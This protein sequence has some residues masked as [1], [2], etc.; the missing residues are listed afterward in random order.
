M[1]ALIGCIM[2][3]AVLEG[4]L[5]AQSATESIGQKSSTGSSTDTIVSVAEFPLVV[6]VVGSQYNNPF[7]N[8]MDVLARAEDM[9]MSPP[10]L[11]TLNATVNGESHWSLICRRENVK[12][13]SNPCSTLNPGKYPARWIHGGELLQLVVKND[14]GKFEW[15]FFD[16]TPKRENP[17]PSDDALLQTVHYQFVAPDGKRTEDYPLL[18]H[19]YGAARLRFPLENLPGSSQCTVDDFSPYTTRINC[20][21]SGGAELYK[22]HIDLDSALDGSWGWTISCDAKWRFSK[23]AALGPGFYLARWRDNDRRQIVV[24][25]Q[26]GDKTQ[27]ITFDAK[28]VPDLS[29]PASVMPPS[30]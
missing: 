3:L 14:L 4:T 6:K 21:N 5:P 10:I 18:L 1:R 7:E 26:V 19:V 30:K 22:G 15:R 11:V 12:H 9:G 17:P 8:H 28:R 24:L 29:E 16:V 20:V 27:E 23:C 13:E 2:V 25:A